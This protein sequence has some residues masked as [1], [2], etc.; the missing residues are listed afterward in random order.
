MMHHKMLWIDTETTGLNPVD[1]I[2]LE[3]GLRI[4]TT[5]GKELDRTTSLVWTPG[6]RGRLMRNEYVYEMHAKSGLIDELNDLEN[7][8]H[9]T[10]YDRVGVERKLTHWVKERLGGDT[11]SYMPMTGNSISHDRGFL[12]F[13]MP[14]LLKVWHYR[15]NDMSS[16][17]EQMRLVNFKLFQKLP[18][19]PKAHRP[20]EDIDESINLW[21]F[22]MDNF[23]YVDEE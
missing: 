3:I 21:K 7:R 2:L 1:D 13:H 6:W 5:D 4:T 18:P 14:E 19:P 8:A 22:L 17:R 16:T 9:R 11:G 15:N 23:L 10:L 20:Q 12:M